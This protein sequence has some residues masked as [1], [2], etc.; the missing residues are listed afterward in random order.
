MCDSQIW[1]QKRG[2][3]FAYPA[4]NHHSPQSATSTSIPPKLRSLIAIY[5]SPPATAATASAQQSDE[6]CLC[7]ARAN[8]ESCDE[9]RTNHPRRVGRCIGS[10]HSS[11][12]LTTPADRAESAHLN[13][14]RTSR[15]Y[16]RC[17]RWIQWMPAAGKG[18]CL[19]SRMASDSCISMAERVLIVR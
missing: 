8:I 7:V 19:S 14:R 13:S 17:P 11:A 16:G 2:G 4:V 10:L 12:G 15:R 9:L 3:C 18:P 6:R 1:L 5:E